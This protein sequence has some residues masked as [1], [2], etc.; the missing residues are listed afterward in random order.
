[1]LDIESFAR[2]VYQQ[3]PPENRPSED[4]FMSRVTA[5]ADG[6]YLGQATDVEIPR[7]TYKTF[8]LSLQ[9]DLGIPLS[10]LESSMQNFP[11]FRSGLV[12]GPQN[13]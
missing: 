8:I 11:N 13:N 10:R 2:E 4:E 5:I 9:L 3:L 6:L 7:D 1:M 12:Q